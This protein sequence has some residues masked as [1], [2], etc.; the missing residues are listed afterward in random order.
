MFWCMPV[1]VT[2]VLEAR[3]VA[4]F[5]GSGRVM[6]TLIPFAILWSVWQKRNARVFKRV[7]EDVVLVCIA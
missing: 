3:R 4:P 1:F 5:F 2:M 6:W 7:K